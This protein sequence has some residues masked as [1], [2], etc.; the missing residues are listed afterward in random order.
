[1]DDVP[2]LHNRAYVVYGEEYGEGCQSV[3]G[4]ADRRAEL[5]RQVASRSM[6]SLGRKP[7]HTERSLAVVRCIPYGGEVCYLR[8]PVDASE[9]QRQ[10][11]L[12]RTTTR[13]KT[14]IWVLNQAQIG[15]SKTSTKIISTH[16]VLP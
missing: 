3:G 11:G 12:G 2:I 9:R 14:R 6:A 15:F 5:Q 7:R 8:L 1:M 4:N 10:E 13:L 16:P